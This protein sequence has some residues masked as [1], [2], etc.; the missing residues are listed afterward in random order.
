[1]KTYTALPKA[2]TQRKNSERNLMMS[3]EKKPKMTYEEFRRIQTIHFLLAN[4][5]I[6]F[7]LVSGDDAFIC[8]TGIAG[9]LSYSEEKEVSTN[10]E[11]TR[12]KGF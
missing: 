3:E 4:G 2:T 6:D 11:T 10:G 9:L 12:G 5:H 8:I 7:M 1:M